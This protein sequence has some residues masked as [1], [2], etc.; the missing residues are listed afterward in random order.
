MKKFAWLWQKKLAKA[1]GASLSAPKMPSGNFSKEG[2][3]NHKYKISDNVIGKRLKSI[4]KGKNLGNV[5]IKTKLIPNV[6]H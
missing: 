2:F 1:K 5:L 4:N 6:L 3:V